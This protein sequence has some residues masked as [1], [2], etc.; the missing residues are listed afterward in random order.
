MVRLGARQF[1]QHVG[2]ITEAGLAQ[3][4]MR[5]QR[6]D[7]MKPHAHR[8]QHA[9]QLRLHHRGPIVYA[10]IDAAK[11]QNLD[12]PKAWQIAAPFALFLFPHPGSSARRRR[13]CLEIAKRE[14]S[15]AAPPENDFR[16]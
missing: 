1:P 3:A 11:E 4:V 12:Q 13:N 9:Q 16:S 14:I 8:G 5:N 7:G 6:S 15:A 2:Q 10:E